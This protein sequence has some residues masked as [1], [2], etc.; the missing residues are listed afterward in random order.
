MNNINNSV[1]EENDTKQ[2]TKNKMVL[3]EI[4][5]LLLSE[6]NKDDDC[7]S[8]Y[9]VAQLIKRKIEHCENTIESYERQL[10]SISKRNGLGYTNIVVCH[11]NKDKNKIKIR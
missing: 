9:D 10:T 5:N 11:D 3:K 2:M 7:I 4:K 6:P 1:Y 8:L